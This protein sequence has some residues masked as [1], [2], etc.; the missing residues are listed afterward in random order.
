M[1]LHPLDSRQAR[2][3]VEGQAL[4][5]TSHEFVL[6]LLMQRMG[7]VVSRTELSEHIYPQDSD[8]DSTPSRSLS[9]GCGKTARRLDR[10]R[11]RPGLSPGC[12]HKPRINHMSE[13]TL[14]SP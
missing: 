5:L 9:G 3:T 7:A 8:R 2:V 6:A 4:T 10:N 11:A 12:A 13:H 14:T 1:R